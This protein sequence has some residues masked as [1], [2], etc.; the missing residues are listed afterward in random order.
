MVDK[1]QHSFRALVHDLQGVLH[2]LGVVSHVDNSFQSTLNQCQRSAEFMRDVG[3]EFQF[4][5]RQL[6]FYSD[7]VTQR[8]EISDN[9]ETEV[10]RYGY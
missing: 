7:T 9:T 1:P 10:T 5:L 6:V 3:K 4:I 2:I 8:I